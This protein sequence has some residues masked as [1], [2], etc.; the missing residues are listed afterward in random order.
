[1]LLVA[2]IRWFLLSA[3]DIQCRKNRKRNSPLKVADCFSEL[4]SEIDVGRE[5][6]EGQF[7]A[8]RWP[9]VGTAVGGTSGVSLL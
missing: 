2:N 6:G 3:L 7:K 5:V 4:E 9:S 8:I 1:L